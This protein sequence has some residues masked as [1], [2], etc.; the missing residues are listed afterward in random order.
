MSFNEEDKKKKASDSGEAES[1]D[2]S[3]DDSKNNSKSEPA[4]DA[5]FVFEEDSSEE[6]NGV[7]AKQKIDKLK[8]KLEK[9][10]ALKQEYLDGWQRAKADF[11][12]EK[13]REA[14]ANKLS[15]KFANENL[16]LEI[17]PILDSFDMA[18]S[19]KEAWEKA[20]KDWRIGVE[21]IYNQ[22]VTV[23]QDNGIEI[24]NPPLNSNFDPSLHT[25][26]D[27]VK[28]KDKNLENKIL[29]VIQKG[30]KLN[31]RLIREAKVK[32]GELDG[33]VEK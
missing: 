26:V 27:T 22:F 18:F 32:I 2:G 30:Y 12:N 9:C 21:Y 6:G 8:E 17:I 33:G 28:V 31:G 15:I 14:E 25:S 5:D 29:A 20:P 16:I 1:N 4:E 10:E 11:I 3:F 13:K 7:S 23:L 24:I 19:N